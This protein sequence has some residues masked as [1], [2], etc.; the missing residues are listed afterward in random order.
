MIIQ[1]GTHDARWY[2]GLCMTPGWPSPKKLDFEHMLT[3]LSWI[4]TLIMTLTMAHNSKQNN[5]NT[6][7]EI[8]KP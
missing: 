7:E 8:K 4:W 2:E 6:P 1:N 3:H 5:Q